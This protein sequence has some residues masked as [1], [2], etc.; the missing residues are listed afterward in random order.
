MNEQENE[1][2]TII[3]KNVKAQENILGNNFKYTEIQNKNYLF[4][5]EEYNIFI[6]NN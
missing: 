3:L 1:E 4:C 6:N 5:N 2:W